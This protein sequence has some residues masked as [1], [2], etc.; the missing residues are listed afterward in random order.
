M[1]E[2]KG[3][4]HII[5]LVFAVIT[6][7]VF[8]LCL[9]PDSKVVFW[10]QSQYWQQVLATS[11]RG[12]VADRNGVTLTLSVPR[13]SLFV[14]PVFWDTDQLS[15][16]SR[17]LPK[18]VIERLHKPLA[19]RFIW[20]TRKLPLPKGEEILS[21]N[22]KGIY[23]V[24]EMERSYPFGKYMAHLLGFVDIDEKGLA[25]VERQWDVFLYTP[26]E[27]RTLVRDAA[28]NYFE[29]A[30]TLSDKG[31]VFPKSKVILTIDW[32]LQYIV[33]SALQKGAE[34]NQAEWGAAMCMDP[35]TGEILAMS[36]YPSFD[37]EDRGTFTDERLRNNVI[38]RVY[39]PGSVLK[40]IMMGIAMDGGYVNAKSAFR[41]G[42]SIRIADHVIREVG[43]RAHGSQDIY[44]I[45][46]N[47]CN[48]G[49]AQV[50]M[51]MP[52][53]FT[54]NA[55]KGW[56]FGIPTGVELPGEEEG[57]LPLPSQWWGVVPANISLGQGIAITPIQLA[58]A[59]SAIANGGVLIRP[60]VT[61]E[62]FDGKGNRV[63]CGQRREIARVLSSSTSKSLRTALRRAVVEGTGKQADVGAA[64]VAGKTGT[65]Q[66]AYKGQYL[67]DAH[68]ATFAGF[69][70]HESPHYVLVIVIGNPRSKGY[71]ASLVA[72][73][74]FKSIVE[75]IMTSGFEIN[76]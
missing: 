23:G 16:L 37:P 72:A 28:G 53:N 76:N 41:C 66:V 5:F 17:Y 33:D 44:K 65:A 34:I 63:Y 40:P 2:S 31:S 7:R 24:K 50:G 55:L 10:S 39:E 29:M 60:Y 8:Q 11:S 62:V 58:Q 25:G 59:F 22:L 57:L 36:S 73:P 51:K 15:I 43:G 52:P 74:I 32:R 18:N 75:E 19:G 20:L 35:M 12:A 3:I 71:L 42:G 45:L 30:S 69:W 21:L 1:R 14:D 13:W 56:G 67:K 9:V 47:S 61:R 4:W 6:A 54:Y 68:V 64:K 48:V 38:G 49:M 70:P 26:P 27:V 46:I